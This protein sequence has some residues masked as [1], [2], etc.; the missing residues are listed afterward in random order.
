MAKLG[1]RKQFK[2]SRSQQVRGGMPINFERL[3]VAVG[4]NAQ[5][6]ICVERPGKVD[7]I[8]ISLGCQ[9]SVSKTRADGL[10]NV[11]RSRALRDFLGAPVRELDC[12][13][14]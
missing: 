10:G 9:S 11:E 6:G 3:R 5:I 14:T 13:Q 12:C 7:Q 8:T 4:K 2:H 1:L